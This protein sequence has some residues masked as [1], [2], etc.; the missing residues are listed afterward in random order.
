MSARFVW[1]DLNS[2]QAD[3]AKKFY[4][5]LF[6]WTV[7]PWR[8]EGAPEGLPAYDMLGID[9]RFFG[10]IN[11]LPAEAPAPSHWMGHVEVP[12]VDA[13][14]QRASTAGATFPMGAMEIPTVGRMAMMIDPQGCVVSLFQPAGPMPEGP[15]AAAQGMIGWNE[16]LVADPAAARAFYSDVVGWSWRQGPISGMH[17]ELFGTGEEGGDAGGMMKKPEEMP[18]SAWFL[19]FTTLDLDATVKRVAELGGQVATP[20][21]EVPTVGRLAIGVGPDGSMFGLAQWAPKG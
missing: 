1:W 21:F 8:P 20:P 2:K 9:G 16:L 13:A 14:M 18:G 6:G 10:G 15:P 12:A 17:Y 3:R 19:Y 5:E 4:A 7:Q 11:Q